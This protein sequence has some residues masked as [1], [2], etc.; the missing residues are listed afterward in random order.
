MMW[1]LLLSIDMKPYA[2]RSP[3]SGDNYP[4]NYCICLARGE[5]AVANRTTRDSFSAWHRNLARVW[6]RDR[7]NQASPREPL[8]ARQNRY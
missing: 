2:A 8:D 7:R 4:G 6:C 5:I 1:R 3:V